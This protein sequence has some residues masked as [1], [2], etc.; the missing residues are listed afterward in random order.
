MNGLE[1]LSHG[2]T[3]ESSVAQPWPWLNTTTQLMAKFHV[4][5]QT[6]AAP[7]VPDDDG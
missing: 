7:E 5:R 6:N 3:R 2:R 4:L 1:V